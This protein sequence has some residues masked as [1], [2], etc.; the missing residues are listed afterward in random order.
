MNAF[1]ISD[2]ML[3]KCCFKGIFNYI[4]SPKC[5][6]YVLVNWVSIGSDN[7]L[8]PDRRQAII[9]TSAGILL[10]GSLGTNISEIRIKI[11]IFS[12]MKMHLKMSSGKWRPFCPGEDE[13]KALFLECKTSWYEKNIGFFL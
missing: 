12:F 7:G 9:W 1:I 13:L 5:H 6:I 11:Q 10:I 3:I 2:T 8:L 4:I